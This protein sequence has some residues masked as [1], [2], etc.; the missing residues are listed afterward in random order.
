SDLEYKRQKGSSARKEVFG[1]LSHS[2]GSDNYILRVSK[3]C[4]ENNINIKDF[5]FAETLELN[6]FMLFQPIF[7]KKQR[8][9]SYK[10]LKDLRRLRYDEEEYICAKDL[11][12]TGGVQDE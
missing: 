4:T 7:L 5:T 11:A 12:D 2:L 10:D 9:V 6:H 8:G 3:M 1:L